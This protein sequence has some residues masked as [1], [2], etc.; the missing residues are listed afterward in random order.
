VG[1][2]RHK[3]AGR[4]HTPLVKVQFDLFAALAY[5]AV[6]ASEASSGR[7]ARTRCKLRVSGT[8]G[9][10]A[11]SLANANNLS[12]NKE[13]PASQ[14]LLLLHAGLA[15]APGRSLLAANSFGFYQGSA[16]TMTASNTAAAISD[17]ANGRIPTSYATR[18]VPGWQ[19]LVRMLQ[20]VWCCVAWITC[21]SLAL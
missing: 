19:P 14:L 13:S 15:G 6:L 7:T 17:A 20:C 21:F 18:W 12:V 5:C 9:A 8:T 1:G 16:N 3:Q 2:D 4:W 10:A 11:A